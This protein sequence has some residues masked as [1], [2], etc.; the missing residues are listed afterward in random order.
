MRDASASEI[1]VE[2]ELYLTVAV[3]SAISCYMW[4]E[5]FIR[6]SWNN[7]A[8]S[9]M[10]CRVL[11]RIRTPP[12]SLFSLVQPRWPTCSWLHVLSATHPSGNLITVL[13]WH[14][15]DVVG[16]MHG[17]H[18]RIDPNSILIKWVQA[19]RYFDEWQRWMVLGVEVVPNCVRSRVDVHRTRGDHEG[20]D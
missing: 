18:F 19:L 1:T 7:A 16:G 4:K 13:T 5:N 3:Q 15:F 20:Y 8:T 9:M 2:P 12:P 6:C 17:H 11:E 14:N 10:V